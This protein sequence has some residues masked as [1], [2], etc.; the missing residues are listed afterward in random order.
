MVVGEAWAAPR[1]CEWRARCVDGSATGKSLRLE[2]SVA[3]YFSLP[4]FFCLVFHRCVRCRC[5]VQGGVRLYALAV[6]FRLRLGKH[7]SR[8]VRPCCPPSLFCFVLPRVRAHVSG[9]RE[10][11]G[12]SHWPS[13]S[14]LS[15]WSLPPPLTI[16][17]A[18][19]VRF[20]VSLH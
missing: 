18:H 1:A 2:A 4:P 15:V 3:M 13:S 10:V 5:S 19:R 16:A 17:S 12:V 7:R 6:H 9:V 20:F 8:D 14:P 11:V